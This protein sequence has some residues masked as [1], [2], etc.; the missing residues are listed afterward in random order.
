MKKFIGRLIIYIVPFLV[1]LVPLLTV[2]IISGEL[3][4]FDRIIQRQNEAEHEMLVG[5]AYNEQTSYYKSANANVHKAK[6]M[7]LGTSRVMQYKEYFFLESF[8]NCGGAVNRNYDGY[9]NFL[10]CIEADSL[11][12]Y[13]ILGMDSWV[14]NETWIK[15]N[16]QEYSTIVQNDI[17]KV[18]LCKR[19]FED[20]LRGKW[21]YS[22]FINRYDNI[23][24][25]G[26]VKGT[27]FMK[28]G[29]YYY[30]AIYRN[31]DYNF[32]KSYER[33]ENGSLNFRYGNKVAEESVQYLKE[34]LDYCNKKNIKV[35]GFIPPYAPA[36]IEK[37]EQSSNYEYM[38]K[39]ADEVEP[40]FDEYDFEFYDYID[41]SFLEC[42]DTYFVDGFHGSE[43][44]YGKMLVDMCEKGSDLKNMIDAPQL[45]N[46][47][48]NRYSNLVYF[49]P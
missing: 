1:V 15:E 13:I 39:I 32:D 14:F 18:G 7:A 27:G 5:M 44:V 48:E 30:G 36:V 41:V 42:D 11:P 4:D 6:I 43:V 37:M 29:S 33:I 10:E 35:I 12:E 49:E 47:I 40:I 24:F 23:G 19:I 9:I 45:E 38:G 3:D 46:L 22:N 26:I 21:R 25:N 2:V 8:Y 34:F 17:N 20:Y 31:P 28:D 16:Q